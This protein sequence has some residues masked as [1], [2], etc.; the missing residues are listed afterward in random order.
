MASPFR[1]FRK[2][3]KAMMAITI[4]FAML[5]FVVLGTVSQLLSVNSG[6][7]G[8]AKVA[9]TW[10]DGEITE[11][12]VADRI[13]MRGMI[14]RFL[15]G[16]TNAAFANM[17]ETRSTPA[18]GQ[19]PTKRGIVIDAI[20]LDRR[21]EE[22]G[23]TISDD[24]ILDYIKRQTNDNVKANQMRE[25]IAK[26]SF[27]N[28]SVSESLLF[29]ALA[30][31]LAGREAWQM[32]VGTSLDYGATP[33]QRWD[34][35]KRI[36][37]RVTAQL[38]PVK[39]E[40][41]ID[42][43]PEPTDK[44]LKAFYEE[45]KETVVSPRRPEI[46]FYLP[47][48]AEFEYLKADLA[49]L[50]ERAKEKVTE[51]QIK[52]HFEENKKS[53]RQQSAPAPFSDSRSDDLPAESRS[54][55]KTDADRT[56]NPDPQADND[57]TAG[58]PETTK[59]ET[60][61]PETE[62]P[63]T[64]KP[65]TTKPDADATE[66]PTEPSQDKDSDTVEP[67]KDGSP[68]KDDAATKDAAADDGAAT[69][70]AGDLDVSFIGDEEPKAGSDGPAPAAKGENDGKED[71][72]AKEDGKKDDKKI[73]DT[74]EDDTAV[75]KPGDDEAAEPESKPAA[76]TDEPKTDEPKTPAAGAA[77]DDTAKE[78]ATK[79][80]KGPR[81]DAAESETAS[82][83]LNANGR[84]PEPKLGDDEIL[85]KYRDVIINQI[86]RRTAIKAMEKSIQD[87]ENAMFDHSRMV[88]QWK[89]GD[90]QTPRPK[91]DLSKLVTAANGLVYGKTG[92]ISQEDAF[93]DPEFG[94]AMV[95]RRWNE[96][97]QLTAEG[98]PFFQAAFSGLPD[99]D[100]QRSA[101]A[102]GEAGDRG[103]QYAFWKTREVKHHL[104]EFKTIRAQVVRSWK[105]ANTTG[106]SAR[107]L[108]TK[109][110]KAYAQDINNTKTTLKEQ[111]ADDSSVEVIETDAFSWLT[112]GSVP[113][114]SM[115]FQYS[116][117][118]VMDI[119]VAG[120]N[121]MKSDF[122]KS[123]FNLSDRE[124]GTAMN[125]PQTIAYAVQ[126][127]DGDGSSLEDL[128]RNFKSSP[129]SRRMTFGEIGSIRASQPDQGDIQG[130]WFKQLRDEY[131]L[132]IIPREDQ[133]DDSSN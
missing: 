62:K 112:I 15:Q 73:D 115:S 85:A 96:E 81:G 67:P 84:P 48:R 25:I 89:K 86:A 66:P 10:I 64:V 133:Q 51:E 54:T 49:M 34:Y 40:D 32:F 9:A 120:R 88:K 72:A 53:F 107:T 65:E 118:R 78:K 29:S 94:N 128:H 80:D 108:A 69:D 110:A 131:E 76:A 22:F 17:G 36:N 38:V 18:R 21:A 116:V 129:Y 75:D 43:V 102:G 6:G 12:Q 7:G 37:R 71:D 55:G 124:A 74:K 59:P 56:T 104:P 42:Q 3:Q 106:T 117:S 52:Q 77:K 13:A 24:V 122:M 19:F 23:I 68:K 101:T 114:N 50:L 26:L 121:V 39:V 132:K 113:N 103:I 35:F 45:H 8:Q 2:H 61:K 130:A 5:S 31:E 14:N 83:R 46:G 47:N 70:E 11:Q 127:F 125:H 44:Q 87:A 100:S 63:E 33:A 105:I 97:D 123:V 1:I 119:D 99:F 93:L 98:T 4:V 58:N 92:L 79:D 30:K 126:V 20:L 16:L 41:F 82:K 109:Q 28:R 90:R 27:Y 95:G 111:F 57:A 60:T 91:F